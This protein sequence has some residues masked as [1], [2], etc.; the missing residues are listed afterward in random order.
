MHYICYK[1]ST[2]MEAIH[3]RKQTSFRLSTDLLKRMQ[4]EA[5]KEN[6][7]LN[8]F[9]ENMLMEAMCHRP[10]ATTLNAMKEAQSDDELE[11]LDPN[12]LK[13]YIAAL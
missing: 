1:N 8:N 5:R 9:V 6:R 7:S 4:T 2:A 12:D 11:T 10:N 13:S 3:E